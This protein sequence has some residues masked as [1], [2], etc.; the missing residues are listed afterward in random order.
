MTWQVS[1]RSSPQASF[2][3]VSISAERAATKA[4]SVGY[5][6]RWMLVAFCS[7]TE[8]APDAVA[9]AYYHYVKPGL[10]SGEF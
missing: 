8:T 7:A 5:C 4:A 10:D 2:W 9:A 3:I 6:V 1:L